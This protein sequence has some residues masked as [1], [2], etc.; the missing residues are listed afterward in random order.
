ML[1]GLAAHYVYGYSNPKHLTVY[2]GLNNR[3]S[4]DSWSLLNLKV[5]KIMHKNYYDVEFEKVF[6]V[7]SK[8]KNKILFF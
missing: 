8:F 2:I 1:K 5:S 6:F 4:P 3:T 7:Y